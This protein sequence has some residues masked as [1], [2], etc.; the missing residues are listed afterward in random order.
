[1]DFD[2]TTHLSKLLSVPPSQITI[3]VLTGGVINAAVRASF[4]LPVDLTRFGH[5]QSV[6]SVVLK[7]ARTTLY[8][9]RTMGAIRHD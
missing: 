3:Q 6:R 8:G 9:L 1:M 4:T 2:F 7:H 5:P